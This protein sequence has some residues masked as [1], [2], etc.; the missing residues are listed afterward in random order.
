M[1]KKPFLESALEGG[2]FASR[3]LMAPFYVGLVA[4]LVALMVVFFQ[5]LAHQIPMLW[6]FDPVTHAY[7]MTADDAIMLALSLIDLSLAANLVL[8]VMFSGYENFVSK[9]DI[10]DHKDRPE[11]MGTVDFSALKLKLV[12]SIVAISGIALLKGFLD[13]GSDEKVLTV[14]DEKQLM[15]Q[16]IVHITFVVSGVLLAFM[17]WLTGHQK[18]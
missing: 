18:G 14:D 11:W 1:A 5:E 17:D 4:A 13:L 2:L 16:V 9:L 8:I 12:A 15:W 6:T 7:A 3:W 10:A